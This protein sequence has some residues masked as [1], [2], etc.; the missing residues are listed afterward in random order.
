MFTK[1]TLTDLDIKLLKE[2]Y[3]NNYEELIKK[4]KNGYPIQ[5]LIGNVDFLNTVILVNESVLVPRFETEYLV[6]KVLD[7]MANYQNTP[8]KV[9]DIC[10]GSGCIAISLAKNTNWCVFG[11]DISSDALSLAQEN[12]KLNKV[13][14]KFKQM[15]ILNE[16]LSNKYD[17]YIANPPYLSENQEPDNKYEPT[18][19]LYGG[20]NGLIFYQKIIEQI[21]EI[22]KLIAFEIGETQASALLNII[23]KKFPK[24]KIAVEKDLTGKNRYIF[25]TI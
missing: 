17:I 24:A 15:D 10:T 23:R 5:Y 25:I 1:K 16:K 4:V 6:E 19:A 9:I 12:N 2:K 3:P 7:K 18:I 14:V 21:E 20:D 13:D 8:L 22:P 11:V